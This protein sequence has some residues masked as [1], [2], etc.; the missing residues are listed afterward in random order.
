M[1]R[2]LVISDLH[3]GLRH[4]T[5]LLRDERV[6]GALVAHLRDGGFERL[7]LLGDTIELR[8][9][10]QED[11]F[12]DAAPVLAALG[13]AV[14]HVVLLPGNHDHRLL[15]VPHEELAAMVAPATLE[16]QYPGVWLREDVYATHG[17]YLDCCLTMPTVERIAIGAMTR[18]VGPV[19]ERDAT[20]DDFE[21]LLRPIYAWIHEIAQARG[22]AWSAR[23]QSTSKNAWTAL[24]RR[25]PRPVRARML[26]ALFP[27]AVWSL[28][29]AGMGPLR[30][31]ISG[32]ELRQAGLRA[33]NDVVRRLGID[34]GHV[35]FGHTHRAG[36]LPGDHAHEWQTLTGARLHN[37]GCWTHEPVFR[38][39]DPESPY[40]AGR[41]IELDDDGPPRL[42]RVTRAPA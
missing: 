1:P 32:Y 17:H 3:L 29:R 24:S 28:N 14:A 36:P 15:A 23:G 30:P 13:A 25:G 33:I 26:G 19:P 6:L 22:S 21:A 8:H 11:A 12:A 27:A 40:A 10:P 35:I 4:G 34:A 41:A 20:P 42:V 39:A 9:G 37:A 38:G 16:I 31:H 5:D 2:T 7:V 18:I